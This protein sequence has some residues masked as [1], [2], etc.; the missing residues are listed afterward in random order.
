MNL[1]QS[2]S[3][4]PD[5]FSRTHDS[6]GPRSWIRTSGAGGELRPPSNPTVWDLL[7]ELVALSA[8]T[9]ALRVSGTFT[10]PG[11]RGLREP[12]LVGR[13]WV[14]TGSGPVE[15][16]TRAKVEAT[17][18]SYSAS[19]AVISTTIS[20]SVTMSVSASLGCTGIHA[21]YRTFTPVY[22]P[23]DCRIYAAPCWYLHLSVV[24]ELATSLPRLSVNVNPRRGQPSAR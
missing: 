13:Y 1:A 21:P 10:L 4:T 24:K 14:S 20:A 16:Q 15:S 6:G 12:S 3:C 22:L 2:L 7:R 5:N 11:V 18:A 17:R 9:A 8:A 19:R 23:A